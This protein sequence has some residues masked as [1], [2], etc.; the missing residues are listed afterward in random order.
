[1]IKIGDIISKRYNVL[2]HLG[3]GGMAV[4]FECK[5]IYTDDTVAVK[6]L[7][8]EL[9]D[10]PAMVADFKKEVKSS[11]QMSHPNI[12]EIYSEG[13]WNN[14][15]YLVLE[16]LKGETLLDKIEYYTK[17]S[18]KESCQ[19]MLQLLDAIQYTHEHK[20]IHR[21]IKP[22]NVFYLS[23]GVVKLGDFG[24]A[25]NE[26]E[27]EN[28]GKILGSVHFLA[29]EVLTGQPFSV[30]SDIYAAGITFFQLVTGVLPF[31]GSTEEVAQAQVKKECPMPSNFSTSIPEEIDEVILKAVAKNPKYRYK[32]ANEFK[33]AIL[34]FQSGKKQKRSI[35]KRL[36]N[37]R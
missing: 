14:R 3:T 23:N 22:Q 25:K 33:N 20:I 26:K 9:L 16:Y 2:S 37:G 6:I 8:E 19:I 10:D 24:I 4:V 30:S 27:A 11:V 32:N 17:F 35:F 29:P 12:M 1:M 18:V 5:D 36:F 15:P 34:A 31:D 21:D 13:V 7:K 28:H